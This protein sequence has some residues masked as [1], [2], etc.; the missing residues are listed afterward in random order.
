[1]A[2]LTLLSGP[3]KVIADHFAET[4]APKLK[5]NFTMSLQYAGMSADQGDDDP[6]QITLA[7]KQITRPMPNIIYEDVNFYNFMTKVATKVD[8]GVVTVT[9]YDDRNNKAHTIFKNYMETVS[10]ITNADREQ[11]LS[12]DR[13]GQSTSSVLGPLPTDARHGPIKNIRVT[14]LTNHTGKKVIYDFLNPKI[15][16][17]TLDEL[18]MTQSDV[19]TITFTFMYDSYHVETEEGSGPSGD[20]GFVGPQQVGDGGPPI[21]TGRNADQSDFSGPQQFGAGGGHLTSPTF[22]GPGGFRL[23]GIPGLNESA[24]GQRINA[25]LNT[26][27]TRAISG[28]IAQ[29]APNVP[30][31]SNALRNQHYVD[32]IPSQVLSNVLRRLTG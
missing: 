3:E 32:G 31:I 4:D 1:M 25:T 22:G 30:A 18:D 16:N 19:N 15:Q 9:L 2:S 27:A 29:G 20:A 5:F 12:L 28:V 13:S 7:I 6:Y 21:G 11:A 8:F 10:P 23:P 17:V 24:I 14:H 26:E